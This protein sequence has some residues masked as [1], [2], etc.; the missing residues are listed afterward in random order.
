MTTITSFLVA[1]GFFAGITTLQ[2]QVTLSFNPETGVTYRYQTEVAQQMTQSLMGQTITIENS[3]RIGYDM[4]V[5][6]KNTEQINVKFTYRDVAIQ[7]SS[8]ASSFRYDSRKPT[9]NSSQGDEMMK[10]IFTPLIGQPYNAALSPDGS[11]I[12]VWGLEAIAGSIA[13]SLAGMNESAVAGEMLKSVLNN[14]AIKSSIEQSFKIY[15]DKAVQ[16]NDTWTIVQT[17]NVGGMHASAESVYRLQSVTADAAMVSVSSLLRLSAFEG[18]SGNLEGTIQ[19]GRL[20]I[21]LKT[22][23][24]RHSD[25]TQNITGTITTQGMD[26]AMKIVSAIKAEVHVQ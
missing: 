16:P 9:E 13:K 4:V 1:L 5:T 25:I 14:E 12:S 3:I 8:P 26:V 15:P 11:V 19:D 10:K 24:P 17:M 6:E 21:D 18:M 22:G 23:L 20:E 2:A 7:V